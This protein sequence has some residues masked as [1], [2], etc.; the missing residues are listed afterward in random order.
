VSGPRPGRRWTV[1]A[2]AF[3]VA[4]G[5]AVAL[6]AGGSDRA[7]PPVTAA[8]AATL[9]VT[10]EV[11]AAQLFVVGFGGT[12]GDS[13]GVRRLAERDWGGVVVEADNAVDPE[14]VRG[15]V[16]AIRARAVRAGHQTPL[17]GIRQAGGHA[18]ALPALPPVPQ[19]DQAVPREAA[20]EATAAAAALRGLGVDLTLAP[21][22]DLATEVGPA[23]DTGFSDDPART[24]DLVAAAVHAYRLAGLASAP[25]SFP[26]EG[27]AS[28]DPA[29]GPATVGLDLDTLR[30]ADVAPFAA[31]ARE[32][33]VIQMS[34]AMYVAWDGVTPATLAPEAYDLL[35]RG[36]RFGGV[37]L[38]GDLNAVTAATGGTVAAAAVEALRAGADLLWVPG[39]AADQE[40]AYQAL[41]AALRR[42]GSLQARA[43]EALRRVALLRSRYLH[44]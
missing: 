15:L 12:A 5:I 43:A 33:P 20:R 44:P 38:S 18:S 1:V 4:A 7:A 6:V 36:A 22:A 10:P 27:A 2:A 8:G 34:G 21:V 41:V 25:G 39:D 28:R 24:A 37:A 14:Q 16:A 19:P 23:A 13:P 26:G 42:D 32:A 11:A 29:E 17:I 40:A 9:P 3:A 30:R 35:R 31:A